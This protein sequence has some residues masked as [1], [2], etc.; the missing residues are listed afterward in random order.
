MKILALEKEVPGATGEQFRPHLHLEAIRVWELYQ[1]G[2]VREF[3]FSQ[4][5]HEAVLILECQDAAEAH[6]VL[7]TLPLVREGLITFQ[8]I[9]LVPYSGFARLFGE[10]LSSSTLDLVSLRQKLQ[11]P[12]PPG[13]LVRLRNFYRVGRSGF[14]SGPS[15]AGRCT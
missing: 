8:V 3:Y 4:D 13:L 1:A 6:Q 2:I 12:R 11:E 5:K 10:G 14:S 7:D 15:P 9:A